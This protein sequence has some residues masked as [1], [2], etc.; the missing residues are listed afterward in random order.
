MMVAQKDCIDSLLRINRC[1]CHA[2]EKATFLPLPLLWLGFFR[3]INTDLTFL[4]LV[5][6]GMSLREPL[7]DMDSKRWEVI[8]LDNVQCPHKIDDG[9]FRLILLDESDSLSLES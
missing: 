3:L 5:C 4:L 8:A 9:L 1:G 6:F 2:T 7:E